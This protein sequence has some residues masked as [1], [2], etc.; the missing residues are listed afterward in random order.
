LD[1]VIVATD[2]LRVVSEVQGFGGGAMLTRSDHMSGTDR[3]AEV[4]S[5]VAGDVFINIQGDEPLISAATIDAVCEPFS[6][7]PEAKVTTA[8][9]R[10]ADPVQIQSPHVVK[11]VADSCGRALYFSRSP[12]PYPRRAPVDYFKH[13]GIYGYRREV[14]EA[15]SS[16]TPS[17]LEQAES[18][19]QLRFLENGVPIYV[20][21][22]E[23]DSVGIDT[24]EDIV[25][26]TPLL[27]NVDS[28]WPR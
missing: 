27:E 11:V 17:R 28:G 10:L 15:L 18:L 26:V 22:V 20:V 25:R 24:P 5:R 23:E 21:E 12:I 4:A 2:D 1:D 13:V 14:L 6:N 3:V 9:V 8:R 19:E 7:R 16:L